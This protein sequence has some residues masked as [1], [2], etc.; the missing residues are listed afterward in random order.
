MTEEFSVRFQAEWKRRQGYDYDL[1]AWSNFLQN[2]SMTK[3]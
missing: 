2:L 3:S 1:V